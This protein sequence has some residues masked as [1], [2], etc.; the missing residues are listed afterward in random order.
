MMLARPALAS[1]GAALQ[2]LLA[3]GPLSER[4][5]RAPAHQGSVADV[6]WLVED[7]PGGRVLATARLAAAL[8]LDA[9]RFFYHVGCVVHA[10]RELRL[11]HRQRTLFLSNDYTGASELCD[12]ALETQDIALPE[13][14]RALNLL[15]QTLLLWIAE[16]RASYAHSLV[17]ALPGVRDAGGGSP[18]WQGLGHHF[19]GGDPSQALSTEGRAW[20]GRV[21]PLMPRHPL[22]ASFLPAAAQAAI[23][24]PHSSARPLVDVLEH[25]GFRYGH[26]VDVVDAG[27]VLEAVPDDLRS[28]G[29]SLNVELV[30]AD[31][32]A[33]A[34]AVSHTVLATGAQPRALRLR[35]VLAAGRLLVGKEDA[36]HLGLASGARVRVTGR[37]QPPG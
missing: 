30:V 18:F 15:L 22:Y 10:A 5:D 36:G 19:Y 27:P 24:Q 1:D 14:A 35:A 20:K 31:A 21:A 7:Q 37:S 11:F 23:A 28:I 4:T 3:R 9:P 13:Q 6:V 8:G 29:T 2:D 16:H 33:A 34:E 12:V 17:L 26:H 32:V 25:E